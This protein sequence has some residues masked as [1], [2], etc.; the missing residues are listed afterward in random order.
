MLRDTSI[1]SLLMA[2]PAALLAASLSAQTTSAPAPA[3][4]KPEEVLALTPLSVT[5]EKSTGYKVSSASTAKRT[6]TALSDIPQTVDI[7]T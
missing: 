7:V 2:L 3:A 4:A 5:A 6:N 1:R